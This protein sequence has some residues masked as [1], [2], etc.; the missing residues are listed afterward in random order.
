MLRCGDWP[1]IVLH[2]LPSSIRS[3][4]R[5]RRRER[6]RGE[7]LGNAEA[8]EGVGQAARGSS[9]PKV[10]VLGSSHGARDVDSS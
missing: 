8:G 3:S 7:A 10:T 1:T 6:N 4:T 9:Y 2:Y 5:R